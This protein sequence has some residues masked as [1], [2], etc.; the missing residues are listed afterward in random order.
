[1]THCEL[2]FK[3]K[4]NEDK[5]L[6][7]SLRCGEHLT[8][9]TLF[10]IYEPVWTFQR[11]QGSYQVR[12]VEEQSSVAISVSRSLDQTNQFCVKQMFANNETC[13]VYL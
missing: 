2:L 3:V 9:T 13:S 6:T 5:Q 10:E 4:S 8:K 1:M 7:P 11:L 12:H